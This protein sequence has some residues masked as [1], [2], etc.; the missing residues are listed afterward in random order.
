METY[1][2]KTVTYGCASSPYLATRVLQLST[3]DEASNFPI[4]SKVV[5]EDFYIDDC[6]SR[7]SDMEKFNEMKIRLID[8]FHKGQMALYKT[9]SGVA[10]MSLDLH[11]YPFNQDSQ[12]VSTK[13]LGMLWNSSS[14]TFNFKVTVNISSKYTKCE[15]LSQI[16]ESSTPWGL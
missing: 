12:E 6:L 15:V 4:A 13:T 5:L 16:S 2:F 11:G 1:R 14:G 3:I 8:L 10:K 7:S 9:Q